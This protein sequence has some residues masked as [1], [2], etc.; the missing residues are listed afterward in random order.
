MSNRTKRA[1]RAKIKAKNARIQK[2]NLK[3]ELSP[4]RPEIVK[5]SAEFIEL[6]N[7]LPDFSEGL[8]CVPLIEAYVRNH[9]QMSLN[10]VE[11][12][13]A[14]IFVFY[15]HWSTSGSDLIEKMEL[16]TTTNFILE[17]PEFLSSLSGSN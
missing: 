2:Q 12:G 4:K 10:D 8:A 7:T 9:P 6:F 11:A 14:T 3:S 17:K 1:K 13:I 5:M 16:I 15:G